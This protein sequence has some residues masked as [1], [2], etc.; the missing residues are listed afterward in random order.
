MHL[1]LTIKYCNISRH[2]IS[3][4][5]LFKEGVLWENQAQRI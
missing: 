2:T 1:E 4:V 3:Y 5:F